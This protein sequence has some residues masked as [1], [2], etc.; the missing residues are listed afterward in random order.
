MIIYINIYI[1]IYYMYNYDVGIE[2][3]P[4]RYKMRKCEL[5]G[6]LV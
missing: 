6:A 2:A 3:L 1:Y 4:V 5:D